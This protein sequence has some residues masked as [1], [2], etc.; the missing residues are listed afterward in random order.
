VTRRRLVKSALVPLD[1]TKNA[2]AALVF[3]ETVFS[4]G[5][6]VVL[7]AIRRPEA[8]ERIGTAPGEAIAG[9]FA[10]PSGGVMGVV[11][12][13]APVFAETSEQALERQT[14]EASDYLEGL[15]GRLRG[16]G[17]QVKTEVRTDTKTAEAIIDYAKVM[18]PTFIAMVRSTHQ[19]VGERLFGSVARHIVQADVAPVL[20]V[21]GT[22]K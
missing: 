19:S 13:G 10:G 17:L 18:K 15:A 20:L 6:S 3:L 14:D 8:P 11:T 22:G 1:G 12:P 21:P 16:A 7:L 2:E 9:G 5:D 4:P